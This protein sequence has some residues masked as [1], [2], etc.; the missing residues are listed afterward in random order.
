MSK[1]TILL[2]DDSPTN[3]HVLLSYLKDSGFETLI[4]RSG[5]GALRQVEYAQ[6]DIILLDVMMPGI[7]GF[8]TCRRLKNNEA[9]REIPILFMT[10]LS[11]TVDKVRGFEAGGVDYITKPLQHEE[12]LARI[13]THLM[14]RNL[15]KQLQ[16]K[17]RELRELNASKDKFFSIIAH[18]LRNP[19]AALLG[20][21]RMA[22]EG[23]QNWSR[24][25]IQR[26]VEDLG[27]SA[28]TLYELLE[29]LLNWSRLQRGVMEYF[30]DLVDIAYTVERNME[31]FA[32]IARQ[33]KI[34]LT[35]SLEP[36]IFVF[37]DGKMIDTV[38]RNLL[39]NALKFTNAGGNIEI[40]A[41]YDDS[42]ITI[43]V[44]DTGVGIPEADLPKLFQLD[45][46]YSNV[47]TAGEQ[48]TGLGLLLCRDLIEKNQGTIWVESTIGVGTTFKFTLPLE[49]EEEG[50]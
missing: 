30:P 16:E 15:Q 37:A 28:E 47:G 24:D 40:S 33:K 25:E 12:V 14:I 4:A 5:E 27:N 7:D 8:E 2:V 50:E 34:T 18:D 38:I 13:N 43:A 26:M 49:M 41:A 39:S 19:F 48:G 29:N 32:T 44:A 23:L 20:F 46:K 21:T 45:V 36:E 42:E 1:A 6:P 11:D 17:N 9:T 35:S 10:A 3:L 31:L 22:A